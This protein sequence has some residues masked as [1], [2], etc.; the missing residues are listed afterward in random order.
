MVYGAVDLC[1]LQVS[2]GFVLRELQ[3]VGGFN[4]LR[5]IGQLGVLFP[6]YVKIKNVPYHQPTIVLYNVNLG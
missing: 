6:I 3:L 1:I 4:P 2:G 5:N